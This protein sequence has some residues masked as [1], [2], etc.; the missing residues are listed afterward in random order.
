[1]SQQ[2][3]SDQQFFHGS[4]FPFRE[5]DKILPLNERPDAEGWALNEE[6]AAHVY[7]TT[8]PGVARHYGRHVYAVE[9]ED[10]AGEDKY[11]H[12][13][14]MARS[15]TVLRRHGRGLPP[16]KRRPAE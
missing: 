4:D 1:M 5:G 15:A 11:E 10:L 13:S 7:V 6:R 2:V 9:P 14:H 8:E 12:R 3:I 16:S